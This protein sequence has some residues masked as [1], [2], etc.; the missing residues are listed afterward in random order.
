M[1]TPDAAAPIAIDRRKAFILG[2]IGLVVIV[3][4]FWKV[5]PQIG[6]YSDALDALEAMGW[7]AFAIIVAFVL[8]YLLAYGLPFRAAIASLPFWRSEQVN[9][10][11]FAISNGVPAGGAVGL[12][13][14]F[15][16]LASYGVA[17][18]VATAGIT[19]VGIWST[20]ISLGFPILGVVAFVLSGGGSQ[21][22]GIALLGLGILIVAV[23]GFVAVMRSPRLAE[24][25]GR[26]GNAL[27]K[28][29][30]GRIAK[31][32]EVDCVAPIVKFRVD[33]A[34][35][36]AKRWMHLTAAQVGVALTQFLVLYVALRGVQGWDEPGTSML[37]VFAA[38]GISQIM[39]MVPITPGGLGTVDALL[40]SILG[41]MG[42]SPG[43]ATAADLVWR[44]VSYVPQIV[45]GI[46][47]LV[48]WSRAAGRKFAAA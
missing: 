29:L 6:S 42:V 33:M 26:A 23:V 30:R 11:A 13:V 4:I 37:A 39:L 15:G 45:I 17:P 40:I 36:L 9:Q 3:L 19:A 34:D 35:V 22:T 14:Q 21:Y 25:V 31:L 5:I 44:A 48:S 1:T 18:T 32:R 2:G 28:P 16:M 12:A 47:A 8:L 24:A 43:D 46:V 27:L 41:I 10:A 38:F 20:F 7:L